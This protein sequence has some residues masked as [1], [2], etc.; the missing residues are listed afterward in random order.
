MKHYQH[1]TTLDVRACEDFVP[2]APIEVTDP[3][4]GVKTTIFNKGPDELLHE[5]ILADGYVLMN[6]SKFES[7]K[8]TVE[9]LTQFQLDQ[10][11]Y[12]KRAAAK[13]GLISWMAAGNM[14]RVR[15][16]TWTV[17]QLI[18]LMADPQ[19]KA[20]LEF[21]NTLSF[22]LAVQHL[23]TITNTLMTAEIK[24]EW[25]AELQKHFYL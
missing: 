10:I 15:G 25:A 14:S 21:V 7:F 11:R 24:A 8:N 6:K 22:E 2:A 18:A 17:P 4:T 3:V 12:S 19:V 13:D 20:L 5:K 23:Q 16:G 1:P 9:T